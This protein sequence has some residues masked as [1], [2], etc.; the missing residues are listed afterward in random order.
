[1]VYP[2]PEKGGRGK[3]AAGTKAAETSGFSERRLQQARTVL[4]N[5]PDLA[6]LVRR[7]PL[8]PVA[9]R[10]GPA[11]DSGAAGATYVGADDIVHG[12]VLCAAQGYGEAEKGAAMTDAKSL[13]PLRADT[14]ISA[15]IARGGIPRH[16]DERQS[17]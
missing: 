16:S 2:E 11:I 17:Q 6:P 13:D 8:L 9:P 7:R 15:R 4:H 14:Y 1:M 3:K 5:A 12:A 10:H